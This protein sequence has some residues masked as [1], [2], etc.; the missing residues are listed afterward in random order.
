MSYLP[1]IADGELRD[2]LARAG[3]VVIEGPKA[4]GKTE[5]ARRVAASE[6]LLDVDE[7]ARQAA[8][9]DPS[10]VLEGATPRLIDEWHER[11]QVWDHAR[12]AVDEQGSRGLF[13]LTGSATPEGEAIRH[14]GAGRFS[15]LRMRPMTLHE[16]GFTT[17]AVSLAE[18]LAGQ[19]Q[20]A[21]D[22]GLSVHDVTERLVVGGW[23]TNLGL[24]VDQA[25]RA[26]LDYLDQISR[27]DIRRVAGPRRDPRR[28]RRLL[29]ALA[30]NVATLTPETKLAFDARDGAQALSRH[31][32]RDY[33]DALERLMVIEPQPAWAP[34]LRS[35]RRLRTSSK[36]HFCDPGL[37][38]AALGARPRALLDDPEL[39]GLL[40]ESMVVR[41]LR[42]LAQPLGGHV[43][44]YRDD[45]GVE[46]DAIVDLGDGRWAA[47]EVKLGAR[48]VD[49]GAATLR[50]F[51]DTVDQTRSGAP[52]CLAVICATGPA[53]RRDDGVDVVP[54]GALGP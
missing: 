54:V 1:R 44:H 47:F 53:Y 48:L 10:L 5:T 35:R 16:A 24:T 9:I 42:V 34:H 31:T 20:Q 18:L 4:S 12:R 28:V 26:N 51:A 19:P 3:A 25:A 45:A 52:A 17:R 30:R 14:T 40:F 6:V 50:R 2:R 23:P 13:V 37:A 39:L 49:D 46:I 11:P 7:A 43:S 8:D 29:A 41:D 38:A 33:L 21:A 27:V 36:H 32:V 15:F 22:P